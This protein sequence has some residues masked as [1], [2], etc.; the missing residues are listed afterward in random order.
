MLTTPFPAGFFF[1]ACFLFALYRPKVAIFLPLVFSCAYLVRG[2]IFGL[3]TTLLEIILLGV[4]SG[5]WVGCIKVR[6]LRGRT[7]SFEFV[8]VILFL[9]AATIS[10]FVAPHPHTAWGVWKAMVIEPIIYVLTIGV[11]IEKE[12]RSK[13]LVYALLLGGLVSALLSLVSLRFGVDFWRLRGIYDVPNS[14]ALI[15]APLLTMCV[16]G[17][18]LVSHGHAGA[19]GR[20][21]LQYGI[22]GLFFG[23]VLIATQSLVGIVAVVLVVFAV[24]MFFGKRKK[25]F[26]ALGL[27]LVLGIGLQM[28]TG[29]LAHLFSGQSSSLIARE[30]IWF[31]AV[32][33]IEQYPIIGTGLGT[34]E[35]LYQKKLPEMN[36]HTILEWVVRDPHNF[37]LSFWLNTGLLGLGAMVVLLMMALKRFFVALKET[38]DQYRIMLGVALLTLIIFGLFDVPYLKNDLALIW[39][40]LL[41]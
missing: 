37:I 11:L 6:P 7:L 32:K 28:Q 23:G 26:L 16:V 1:L 20:A 24:V 34:F 2:Q 33:M 3:P 25:I 22:L 41:L 19:R 36:F 38:H 31:V 8:L 13:K 18:V 21:P 29:K 39:W 5:V 17:L 10:V 14:L 9:V 40:V 15:V 12:E 30:Q 35:P 4:L 27:I